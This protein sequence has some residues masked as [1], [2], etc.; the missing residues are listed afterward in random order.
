M[1]LERTFCTIKPDA[2]RAGK[3][4]AILARIEEGGFKIVALRMRTLTRNEVE[5]FYDVHRSRPFYA[6]LCE[7][8]SSGA[9]VTMVLEADNAILGLR[10][11]MGA[12]DPA[13][14]KDG[15]IRKEFGASVENNAIHGS[16]GPD[17]AK[18]EI[19]YFFAGIELIPR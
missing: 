19:G 1:T 6:S 10:T 13:K 4:G 11:L 7:F 18:Q 16:D 2:V 14:A 3:A 12:T 9:C 5:L 8:M 15:T 17:T